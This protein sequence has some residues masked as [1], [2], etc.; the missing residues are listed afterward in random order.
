MATVTTYGRYNEVAGGIVVE[1]NSHFVRN[2]ATTDAFTLPADAPVGF[3]FVFSNIGAG[4]Q[5]LTAP[6][7]DTMDGGVTTVAQDETVNVVK[8]SSTVWVATPAAAV[9]V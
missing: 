7:G 9:D 6:S 8:Q 5:T 3:R 4:V 2:E 1:N